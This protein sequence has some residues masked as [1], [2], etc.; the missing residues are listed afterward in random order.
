MSKPGARREGN[1][2]IADV[3]G[4]RKVELEKS[5]DGQGAAAS[6]GE[7]PLAT[8]TRPLGASGSDSPSEP[9]TAPGGAAA[10]RQGTEG[11]ADRR[12]TGHFRNT[13][14]WLVA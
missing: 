13:D 11:R 2:G 1:A 5:E 10:G 3:R 7:T 4:A 8:P 6:P 9:A 14:K 12:P